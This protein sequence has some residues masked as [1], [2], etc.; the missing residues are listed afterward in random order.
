[1]ATRKTT[2]TYRPS[3]LA[4]EI[5]IDPKVLRAYLRKNHTRAAEAKNTSW[6]IP[7]AVAKQA[8]EAFKKNQAKA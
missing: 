8:R 5:G 3:E 7:E 2:K 1:M 6:I 4:T